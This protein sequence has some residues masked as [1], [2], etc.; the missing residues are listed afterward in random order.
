M[1]M[2][3]APPSRAQRRRQPPARAQRRHPGLQRGGRAA[4][5]VRAALSGARRAG[6]RLR[7]HLRQRRQPRPLGGAAARAVRSAGPTSRASCCST[8]TT[9]STW[10]SWPASSTAAASAS[11]RSTPTCRTRPRRSASCSR[12]WTQGH[13]YVGG[14]P[15]RRAQ[16]AGGA[17]GASRAMNRLRERITHIQM[18]DQGCML[19]AYSRDIVDAIDAVPRGQHLHPGARLHVR[20]ATRPRS[21]SAHEERARASRSTRS[22]A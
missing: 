22:T 1:K 5:A 13:D 11:S 8:A 16:D 3:D 14:D 2:N 19:R 12:R 7:D 4:G 9:A 10:R 17:A 18:T 6:R 21:R 20:A 15:P